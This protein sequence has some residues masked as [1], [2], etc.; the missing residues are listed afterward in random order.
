MTPPVGKSGPGTNSTSFSIVALGCLMRCRS[1]VHSSSAL[2]GGMLVAMPDGNAGGAVGQQVG[3]VGGQDDRLGVLAVEGRAE[4]DGLLVD[5]LQQGGGRG[6]QPR[7]GVAVGGGVI[8]VDVAEV[9]L[10]VD[11]RI[12]LGKVLGEAHERVVD[13]L[14]AVRMELADDVADHA[15]AFLIGALGVELQ[16]AH[17][18]QDAPVHRLEAVAHVGQR[19]AHDGG[20]RVGEIALL[21]GILELDGLVGRWGRGENRRFGHGRWLLALEG[22]LKCRGAALAGV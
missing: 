16:L 4:I 5:A 9:A 13:G 10:A 2:C 17:G 7:L 14:V 19:A 20:E 22:N 15:R 8:A 6:R 11:Q 1:A 12:A 21:Q 3:E 18:V